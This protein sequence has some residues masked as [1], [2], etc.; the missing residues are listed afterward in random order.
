MRNGTIPLRSRI[1]AAVIDVS[2]SWT[3]FAATKA[4]GAAARVPLP[5]PI[6]R[7]AVEVYRRY[8]EVDLSDVAPESIQRGFSSFDE[9]F[10]RP[11]K[12]GA[13]PIESAPDFSLVSPCD[14]NIRSF[15]VLGEDM[16]VEAKGLRYS[17]EQ[18]I[19]DASLAATLVGGTHVTIYLHPR[20]YHRVHAP[21]RGS[22][23]R[24]VAIPGRLL[25]V[26]DAA[27]DRNPELFTVNERLVHVQDTETGPVVTVMVAAFGV[28]HMT[29]SY[30]G[31]RIHPKEV[32]TFECEPPVEIER[33][34]ELGMFHLGS[35]V[36]VLTG[37]GH[38]PAP[39]LE[40]GPTRLGI[41]IL[42]RG[43][44]A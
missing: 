24:V 7:A 37:P 21:V 34:E 33:G 27:L 41:G 36:V 15:G 44:S 14:G 19:G 38:V 22:V 18:L 29:C 6:S 30:L 23:R 13:R 10:T 1:A 4:V 31:T 5:R 16:Q 12:P 43:G 28:G 32:E 40:H 17:V 25:P 39:D 42:V 3:V 9:F 11:L 20:D 8:F 26:N 2:P 35:T